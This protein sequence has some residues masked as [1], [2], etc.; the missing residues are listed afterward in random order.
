MIG[1]IIKWFLV[2]ETIQGIMIYRNYTRNWDLIM[3]SSVVSRFRNYT[4]NRDLILF[5][6]MSGF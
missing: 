4:R 5:C 2:L 6:I 1:V 3:I